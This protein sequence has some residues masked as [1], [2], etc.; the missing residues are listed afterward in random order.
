[1][2]T[3]VAEFDSLVCDFETPEQEAD[4]TAWL[5]TKV[6]ASIADPRPGIPHDDVMRRLDERI[7]YWRDKAKA[8]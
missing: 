3:A 1:M 7:A 4:Y 5:R 8:A 2:N 6:A